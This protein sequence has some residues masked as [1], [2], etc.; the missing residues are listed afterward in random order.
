MRSLPVLVAALAACDGGV[1]MNADAGPDAGPADAPVDAMMGIDGTWRDNYITVN[2]SVAMSVC[3][4]APTAIVVDPASAVV[5]PYTGICKPDGSFRIN[6]P[7]R[8][9]A[10]QR[11]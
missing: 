11:I 10:S 5:T 1:K 3:G 7:G 9:P 6:A 4:T 2:G 8:R